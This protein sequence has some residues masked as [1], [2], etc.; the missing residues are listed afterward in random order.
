MI[1]EALQK[2]HADLTKAREEHSREAREKDLGFA[3]ALGEVERWIAFLEQP[4]ADAAAAADLAPLAAL[5]EE[6]PT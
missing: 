5:S 2:R 6:Q 3:Y 4:A 1:L